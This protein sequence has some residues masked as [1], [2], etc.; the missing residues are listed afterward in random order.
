MIKNTFINNSSYAKKEGIKM[1][2][3][4]TIF[5]HLGTTIKEAKK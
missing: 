4:Y 1:K 2:G 3:N 5:Q